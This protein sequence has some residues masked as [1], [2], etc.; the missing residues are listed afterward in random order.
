M[1]MAQNEVRHPV[2]KALVGLN[3]L[4]LQQVRLAAFMKD[5]RTISRRRSLRWKAA[6]ELV[7]DLTGV[8][9]ASSDMSEDI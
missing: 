1:S 5:G 9:K 7:T 2:Q 4:V 6:L 8:N 3:R